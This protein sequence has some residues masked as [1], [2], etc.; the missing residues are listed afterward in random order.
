MLNRD[1][2][3]FCRVKRGRRAGHAGWAETS[4]VIWHEFAIVGCPV[5]SRSV[6]VLGEPPEK[7]S[8]LVEHL[9]SQDV[10]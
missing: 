8:Y 6:S 9:V 10:E 4:D 1:T 7:C 3:R 5:E 2:C